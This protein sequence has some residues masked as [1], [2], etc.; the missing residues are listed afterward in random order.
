MG[1]AHWSEGRA[2]SPTDRPLLRPLQR[3]H[4]AMLNIAPSLGD[5]YDIIDTI[6]EDGSEWGHGSPF[7]FCNL[8]EELSDNFALTPRSFSSS[9]VLT[10]NFG[11]AALRR[12]A[13]AMAAAGR[14]EETE[15]VN[16][17][18][19]AAITRPRSAATNK[20]AKCVEGMR[21]QLPSFQSACTVSKLTDL[22]GKG[23]SKRGIHGTDI[24]GRVEASHQAWRANITDVSTL[25]DDLKTLDARSRLVAFRERTTVQV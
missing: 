4:S 20:S 9:S 24:L 11:S 15:H 17:H 7:G 23:S 12:P 1:L 13:S 6:N 14:M 10:G 21:N 16:A 19:L 2:W 3:S 5:E 25:D 8:D 18:V 22:A